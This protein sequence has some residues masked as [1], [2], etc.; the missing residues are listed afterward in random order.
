MLIRTVAVVALGLMAQ[1]VCPTRIEAETD[2]PG[3]LIVG[4]VLTLVA[5]GSVGSLVGLN[6]DL[7]DCES[8]GLD[9][10]EIRSQMRTALGVGLASGAGAIWCF[11]QYSKGKNA[12]G[13]I[14][15]QG[16]T[17]LQLS[18]PDMSFNVVKKEF[19]VVV[20]SATF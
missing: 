5:V 8:R 2:N 15:M 4:G 1:L 7:D 12:R 19:R 18:L 17:E 16:D 10:D 14:N 13:L 6:S 9:C 3:Y 11:A 20:F